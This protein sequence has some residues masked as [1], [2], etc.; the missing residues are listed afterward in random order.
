MLS[1][2]YQYVLGLIVGLTITAMFMVAMVT[3][4]VVFKYKRYF[5]S[6]KTFMLKFIKIYVEIISCFFLN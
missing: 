5:H 2:F 4:M 1:I 3:F 6:T